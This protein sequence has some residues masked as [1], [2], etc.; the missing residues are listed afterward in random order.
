MAVKISI[1]SAK[2]LG[3]VSTEYNKEGKKVIKKINGRNRV[4]VIKTK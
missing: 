3:I 1:K 4:R 2:R